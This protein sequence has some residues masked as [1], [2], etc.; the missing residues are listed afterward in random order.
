MGIPLG[1]YYL[2][3]GLGSKKYEKER[4]QYGKEI[5]LLQGIYD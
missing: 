4:F 2:V 3:K 1:S 5:R